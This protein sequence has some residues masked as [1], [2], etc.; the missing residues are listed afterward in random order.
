MHATV[1]VCPLRE[2]L[3]NQISRGVRGGGKTLASGE[4]RGGESNGPSC[5]TVE[6]LLSIVDTSESKTRPHWRSLLISEVDSYTIVCYWDLRN[7]P[8]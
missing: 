5:I 8:D 7:C 2:V 1:L 6:P 4:G 3:A